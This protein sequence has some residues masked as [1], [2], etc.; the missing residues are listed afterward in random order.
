MLSQ[1]ATQL[2]TLL[3]LAVAPKYLGDTSYGELAFAVTFVGFFAV[4][5]N[6]GTK[7]FLVRKIARSPDLLG[8]YLVNSCAMKIELG[9]VLSCLAAALALI[10]GYSERIV[11][12]VEIGCIGMI[13]AALTDVLQGGLQARERMGE[14]ALW[15]ALQQ[16]VIVGLIIAVLVTHVGGA[17]W[18]M[19]IVSVGQAISVAAYGY[20]LWPEMRGESVL[21]LRVWRDVLVGGLPFV[22]WTGILMI[23]GSIDIIMLQS[24]SGSTT[25]GWYNLAYTWVGIPIA[26]PTILMTVFLPQ[27][28]TMAIR[29]PRSFRWKVNQTLC[30]TVL[31]CTPMAVG[32][33]LVAGNLLSLLGYPS[34]YHHAIV[35]IQILAVHIPIVAIDMIMSTA[36]IA[37]DRQKAWV[38]VGIVAAVF[39]PLVNL[40]AIPWAM[41]RFSNGAIGASIVTVLTEL[42]MLAGAIILRPAGV[43]NRAT[44]LYILRCAIASLAMIPPVIAIA[45]AS[46]PA[47]IA[48][49]VAVFTVA[50]FALRVVS[51][52]EL[53]GGIGETLDLLHRR[54]LAPV[55]TTG[56][57]AQ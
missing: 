52:K 19:A 28:S 44:V 25:V 40:A 47:K 42:V 21:E 20:K 38:V 51:I 56:S 17:V 4:V 57:R 30:A 2:V 45:G 33:A 5:A 24:M 15:G 18:V 27:L 37:K 16:Y 3:F 34:G 12:L 55:P 49:G 11:L 1:F 10:L 9:L 53:R 32:V 26:I 29:N 8:R 54:S 39:N 43:M 35:L 50:A 46:L 31:I 36:L 48:V 14:M 41:H 22:L 23:Y 7:T 6:L 13:F